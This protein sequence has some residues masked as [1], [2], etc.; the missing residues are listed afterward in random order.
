MI[1]GYARVSTH[2]QNLGLQIQALQDYQCDEII[3]EKQSGANTQR[4]QLSELIDKLQKD[5]TL[6]V[7]KLDRISR[8]TH[9]LLM[10]SQTFKD[11]GIKF[12]SIKDQIDTTTPMGQFFFTITGAISELER[13]IMLQRSQDGIAAARAK[14]IKFGRKPGMTLDN[15]RKCA[16]AYECIKKLGKNSKKSISRLLQEQGI[17]KKT[18]YRYLKLY[19]QEN[20]EDQADI[21]E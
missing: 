8:S 1:Y 4:K 13:D 3:T 5:D 6:V 21:F 20:P 12:I 18:Y 19:K 7:Y 9:H 16:Y 11:K 2:E 17:A 10:L 14:G 15:R